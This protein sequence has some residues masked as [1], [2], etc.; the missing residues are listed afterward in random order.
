VP[1]ADV[2]VL[3]GLAILIGSAVQGVLGFGLGLLA[4]PV[5]ALV[6][7]SLVPSTLLLVTFV[8]PLL[9]LG[10]EWGQIDWRG[11]RWALLGRMPGTAVGAYAVAVAT[12]RVL[13]IAVAVVVLAGVALSLSA[14]TVRPSTGTLLAGGFVSGVTGTATVIGGPPIALVYQNAP[15]PR[16]RATLAVFFLVGVSVS[17]AALAVAGELHR[18]NV[19]TA[20]MLLPF[21]AAGFGLSL[22]LRRRLRGAALRPAVLGLSA[23]AAVVLAGKAILA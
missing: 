2:L 5:L 13:G 20:A 6:D 9:T 23:A 19:V 12:P 15:G 7:T 10:R 4:A 22:L 8:L 18:E 16:I 21:L 11:L 3:A 17:V 14:F 1:A